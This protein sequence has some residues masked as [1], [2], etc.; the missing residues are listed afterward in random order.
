MHQRPCS[1][2]LMCIGDRG[3]QVPV[4]SPAASTDTDTVFICDCKTGFRAHVG[5]VGGFSKKRSLKL[6]EGGSLMEHILL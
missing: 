3:L 4:L 2:L 1:Y 5:S 6:D